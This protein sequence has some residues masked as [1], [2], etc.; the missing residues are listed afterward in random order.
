ME[1]LI[2]KLIIWAFQDKII[3]LSKSKTVQDVELDLIRYPTHEYLREE[4]AFRIAH[5]MMV[6]E[7]IKFEQKQDV[8]R[9]SRTVTGKVYALKI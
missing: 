6:S 4:I 9:L 8:K 5:E 1:K 2:K 7:I 3:V